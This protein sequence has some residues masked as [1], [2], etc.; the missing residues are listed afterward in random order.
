MIV[1]AHNAFQLFNENNLT[2]RLGFE[3]MAPPRRRSRTKLRNAHISESIWLFTKGPFVIIADAVNR[4]DR[5]SD[6]NR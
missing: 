5:T 4:D 6:P 3:T 2:A 1:E